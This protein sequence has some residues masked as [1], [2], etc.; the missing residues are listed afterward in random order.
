MLSQAFY[1]QRAL[2]YLEKLTSKEYVLNI[3]EKDLAK[4]ITFYEYPK[5]DEYLIRVR[6]IVNEEINKIL[7]Y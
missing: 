1:D 3:L 5:S 2:S 6:N 7:N 4:P